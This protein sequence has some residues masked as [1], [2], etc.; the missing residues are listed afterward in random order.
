M[1]AEFIEDDF[2]EADCWLNFDL[3]EL[4]EAS[5]AILRRKLEQLVKEIN[6]L[7]ELDRGHPQQRKRSTGLLIAARPWVFSLAL[8]SMSDDYRKQRS[9]R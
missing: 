4:S 1:L 5:L 9:K 3:L 6:Q 2:V 8:E 7:A